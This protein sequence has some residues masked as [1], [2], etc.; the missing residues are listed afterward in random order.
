MSIKT[1]ILKNKTFSE[2]GY[3][4]NEWLEQLIKKR[5]CLILNT[6][7]ETI[8]LIKKNKRAQ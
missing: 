5:D 1:Y 4:W 7:E 6:F 8:N 2:L 3:F